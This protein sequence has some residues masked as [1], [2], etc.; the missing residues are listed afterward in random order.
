M[1]VSLFLSTLLS[2]KFL[3]YKYDEN[4]NDMGPVKCVNNK[5]GRKLKANSN[6]NSN[7]KPDNQFVLT[8]RATWRG[9]FWQ[10]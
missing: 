5:P 10:I 1:H 7:S 8:S 3:L 6:S 2:N 4:S 9:N